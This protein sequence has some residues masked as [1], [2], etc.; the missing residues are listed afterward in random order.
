MIK[1]EFAEKHMKIFAVAGLALTDFFALMFS[2]LLFACTA[3]M[4]AFSA[5]SVATGVCLI[6]G[7]NPFSLLP[8]IPYWCG[9]VL[10]GA[11][12][13]LSVFVFIG[14]AYLIL[15]DIQLV[16]SYGRY[17]YNQLASFSGKAILP[18]LSYCP[19]LSAKASRNLKKVASVSLAVFAVCFASGYVVCS[20]SA[21]SLGFWHAWNWF[22]K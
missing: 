1:N 18:S 10:A 8:A 22:V 13:A 14:L 12:F 5:A 15:F 17:H 20:V 4:A 2:A 11:L 16:R 7:I 9:A 19:K 6:G 21:G 3:V